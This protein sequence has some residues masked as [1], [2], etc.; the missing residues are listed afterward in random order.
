MPVTSILAVVS[1]EFLT[2]NLEYVDDAIMDDRLC[3]GRD[4]NGFFTVSAIDGLVA[5]AVRCHPGVAMA[6]A[7]L[8]G[9]L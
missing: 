6:R 2:A 8:G 9:I 1:G 4:G 7:P 5:S 3:R